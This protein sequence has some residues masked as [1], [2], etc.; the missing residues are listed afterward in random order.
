MTPFLK[1]LFNRMDYAFFHRRSQYLTARE[2]YL[3]QV[4]IAKAK[5]SLSLFAGAHSSRSKWKA[6]N[7]L[8]KRSRSK[9]YIPDQLADD[10][11]IDFAR[12]FVPSDIHEFKVPSSQPA[13]PSFFVSDFDVFKELKRIRS[14]GS[15][16]DMINGWVLKRY[17]H[18]FAYPLSLLF[19]RCL[20]NCLFPRI[21]KLANINP[22]PKGRSSHRPISLLSCSSKIFERIFVKHFLIPSISPYF[23]RFQFG[24]LPT[25]VGGCSNAVTYVRLHILKHLSSSS[26][27]VRCVQIDLAKAFDKASHSIIL[28]SLQEYVPDNPWLICFVHSFLTNRWQRVISSSGYCSSW[29][30]VTSGVPQGSVLGPILFAIIINKFP[31]LSINSKMIAYAD[32]LVILHDLSPTCHDDNLQADLH[33]VLTWL[34]SLKFSVNVDKFKSITF[35][36][37]PCPISPLLVGSNPIPAVDEIKFLGVIFQSNIKFDCHFS[38]IIKKASSSMYFVKLLWLNHSP[39]DIIWEAYLSLVFSCFSY[40]WPAL[41]DIPSSFLR[42]LCSIEKRA[43]RWSRIPF[44]EDALRSRLDCICLRLVCKIVA[45]LDLHPLSAFFVIRSPTDSLRHTRMLQLPPKTKA[46]YRNSFIKFSSFT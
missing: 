38:S 13:P 4:S 25:G 18:E 16:P 22:I 8:S 40:C 19:N 41:C 29:T 1:F 20:Q 39:P 9:S 23:N 11:N 21:W 10:L 28:S 37:N 7:R 43:C 36:R 34:S 33:T 46:F 27:H 30:P 14:S 6:I 2:E 12:S 17:A 5:F 44:S 45:K 32:D 31:Q 26:G 35:S 24:F 42:K 15:G 3:R